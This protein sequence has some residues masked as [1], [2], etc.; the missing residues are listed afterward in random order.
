[1]SNEDKKKQLRLKDSQLLRKVRNLFVLVLMI[2][3]LAGSVVTT[4][5]KQAEAV[6]C[7]S[8]FVCS[9]IDTAIAMLLWEAVQEGIGSPLIED[10]I[11]RHLNSEENW[12]VEDFFEDFWVKG[13][14]ELTHFLS[15]F[16]MYQVEMVGTLFD[17]KNYLETKRLFFELQAEAHRDYHPSDDFCWFGTG[18]RSLAASDARASLN[19]LAMSERSVDRQLSNRSSVSHSGVD[20]D[21]NSRWLQFVDTYCDPKDNGWGAPGTGLDLACDRDG[22]GPLTATGATDLSRVNLDVDYTRLIEEPRTLDVNFSDNVLRAGEQDVMAMSANLYAHKA[23]EWNMS[24]E[25]LESDTAQKLFLD[26]RAVVARRNVAQASFNAIVSMKASGSNGVVG[27]QPDVGLYMAAILKDLMPAG[28]TDDEIFS[29]LGEN[30]SYYAQLEV[31]GKKIYQNPD[32]FANLYD[33]PANVKRK[34]VAMKAIDL[35][36]DRALYESELRQEMI[37]SV[38]L[39]NSLR[40]RFR[41]VNQ[42]LLKNEDE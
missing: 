15:A 32:F 40:Q 5:P 28:T 4:Q 34:S 1:M 17:A 30:P 22:Q 10:V 3:A 37:L 11:E 6:V 39:S 41:S 26:L 38:M 18:T 8:C 23:P 36:L 19:M 12:I 24:S 42:D 20:S 16:G 29:L 13:L 33:K 2:F 31:L 21:K 7:T 9:L 25:K 35:M 14:V 27:A